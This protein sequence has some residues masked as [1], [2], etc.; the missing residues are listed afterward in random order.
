[1]YTDGDI[2]YTIT[3]SGT[4]DYD[5]DDS[6]PSSTHAG[7]DSDCDGTLTADDCDDSDASSTIIADDPDC[8]GIPGGNPAILVDQLTVGDLIITEIMNNPANTDDNYG[9][10]FELYN[11]TSAAIN[12]NGLMVSDSSALSF[13]VS[14]P[15]V[16][17]ANSFVVLGRNADTTLNGGVTIDYEY[18]GLRYLTN[19]SDELI[20]SNASG[21][22]D[23]VVWDNGATFPDP[24]GASI[25]LNPSFFDPADNDNGANWCEASTD[26]GIGDLGTPGATND[27]CP[28]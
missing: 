28:P 15:L 12:L 21:T 8:D 14:S 18:G 13:T 11:N 17:S 16:V 19:G 10:W 27:S 20:L 22:L 23:E 25:S 3:G 1:M 2:I 5:C 7:I 24:N 6:D 26:I 4:S 9:E